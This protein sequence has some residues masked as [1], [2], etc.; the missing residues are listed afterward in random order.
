M[1]FVVVAGWLGVLAASQTQ[2]LGILAGVTTLFYG[3]KEAGLP[4]GIAAGANP[5][6]LGAFIFLAD[7]AATCFIYPP[8]H[9]AIRSWL[10]REGF[11]GDYLRFLRAKA[12][13]RQ[14]LISR[15][16]TFGLFL[17]MLIPFAINGPLVGALL[18]RLMGLRA[19]QIVPTLM[20]A[21]GV[22]TVLWTGIYALGFQVV[23]AVDPLLP[24]VIAAIV[25]L[26]VLAHG[27]V[28]ILQVWRIRR[29]PV[30]S[31]NHGDARAR[32]AAEPLALE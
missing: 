4:I 23:A 31:T 18:G 8:L 32:S 13:K 27:V 5:I 2:A 20:L 9:Y 15:F 26:V 6:L 24:K 10:E 11:V 29:R 16:G 1:T 3:G 21:I 19:R 12:V 30:A 14:V 28:S 22:T 17:F 25:V 7:A